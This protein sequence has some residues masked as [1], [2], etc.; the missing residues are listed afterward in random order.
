ML[1]FENAEEFTNLWW[2]DAYCFGRYPRRRSPI[3]GRPARRRRSCRAISSSCAK[4]PR[5]HRGQLLLH[6]DLHRQPLGGRTMQRIKHHGQEGHYALQ[7]HSRPHKTAPIRTLRPATGTGPSIPTGMRIA[8]RRLSSRYALPLM[9]T[10]NGLGVRQAGSRGQGER[11]LPY[12]LSAQP[13]P[14]RARRRCRTGS[15]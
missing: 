10:E 8:L 15:S 7:R 9:I 14:R 2:L 6:P 5:L 12:R 11:R 4:A 13:P 1:A 3:C